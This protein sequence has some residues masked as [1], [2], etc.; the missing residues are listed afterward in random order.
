MKIPDQQAR[1]SALDP[2]GSFIVQAP[3]GSCKTEL[4]TQRILSLLASGAQQPEEVLA[5]TFTRKAAEEMR[6]RV[7]DALQLGLQTTAPS[8]EHKQHT[9][10]LA[11]QVIA[12]DQTLQWNLLQNPQRLQIMTIDSFCANLAR[13]MPVLS[14]M[15][16]V[17]KITQQPWVLY[18]QAAQQTISDLLA[19]DDENIK[20]L[21]LHLDNQQNRAMQEI[22]TMLQY[23]EQWLSCL[24]YTSPSPRDRSLSRMPSSA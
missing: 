4:L 15:G 14:R 16:A 20:N 12:Q 5:I 23:R 18:Q 19:Q 1:T 11:Q 2:R 24:L 3:A 7:L 6:L 8:S 10:Q 17:P 13:Q 21:L 22:A 9:W